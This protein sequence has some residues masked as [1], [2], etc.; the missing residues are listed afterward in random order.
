MRV[1]LLCGYRNDPNQALGMSA[2]EGLSLLDQRIKALIDMGFEVTTV[3]AGLQSDEQ[4]RHSRHMSKTELVFD[5]QGDQAT[6]ATNLIAGIKSLGGRGAF[7]LPVEVPLAPTDVWRRMMEESRRVG[8]T[9]AHVIQ[10]VDAE[11]A[12][13]HLGFPL[14]LTAKGVERLNRLQ[15]FSSLIDPRLNFHYITATHP[16]ADLAPAAN[17]L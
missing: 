17:P 12:P 14:F 4:L 16:E 10:T 8:L 15:N 9:D 6:L 2:S 13:C 1:L 5:I 7:V 11:G 3:V